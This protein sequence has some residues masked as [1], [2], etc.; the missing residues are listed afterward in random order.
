MSEQIMNEIDW[1]IHSYKGLRPGMFLAYDRLAFRGKEDPNSKIG[2][3]QHGKNERFLA[4]DGVSFSVQP[5]EAGAPKEVEEEGF[6]GIVAVVSCGHN[7]V[8]VLST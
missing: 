5:G 2:A 1:F 8:A 4:L 3:R 7:R 6:D